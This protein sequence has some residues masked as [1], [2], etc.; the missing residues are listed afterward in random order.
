MIIY[1]FDRV[2][3]HCGKWLPAFSPFP[4]L[5]SKGFLFRVNKSWDC[6]IKSKTEWAT[7]MYIKSYCIYGNISKGPRVKTKESV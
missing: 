4:T 3:K 6:V 5:F 7:F 2:T 1:V